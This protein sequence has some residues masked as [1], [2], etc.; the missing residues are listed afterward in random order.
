MG[1][2]SAWQSVRKMKTKSAE[3]AGEVS[4]YEL[5][6]ASVSFALWR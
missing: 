2:G 5:M 6:R 4:L 1:L 3:K